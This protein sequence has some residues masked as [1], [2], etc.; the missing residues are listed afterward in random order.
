MAGDLNMVAAGRSM[1]LGEQLARSARKYPHKT[2]L[3]A[4]GASID[5]ATLNKNATCFA[6]AL[7]RR[8]IRQGDRIVVLMHNRIETIEAF[9]GLNRLGAIVVPVNYRLTDDEVEYIANDCGASGIVFEESLLPA[10]SKWL[11]SGTR[12][13]VCIELGDGVI[14]GAEAWN[15]AMVDSEITTEFEQ[16]LDHA[17]AFILYTSGT[18]GRPKGALLTHI[19]LLMNSLTMIRETEMAGDDDVWLCGNPLFHVAGVNWLHIHILVGGTL[20]LMPFGSFDPTEVVK[21]LESELITGCYFVPSQWQQICE[22]PGIKDR[23]FRLRRI[24]WGASIAPLKLLEA[25]AGLFSSVPI[26]NCFGQTEMSGLT[27]ILKGKDAIR[28]MGSVG[29]PVL[30]IDVRI[31]SES[32]QDVAVGQVGEIVYRGPTTLL[33]Y[34]HNPEA[35]A[36]A[37]RGGWFH[38]GDLCRI[39]EEGYIWVVD[40]VKDMIVSGG[41]NIYPAEVENAIS[42][43]PG[44]RLVAVVAGPHERWIE[45]PVAFVVPR[46][47]DRAP[48]QQ[49]IVEWCSAF[50]ASY[51]KPT[52]V[53]IVESLPVNASG[54]VLKRVL[55]DQLWG[56]LRTTNFA[57]NDVGHG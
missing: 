39:D 4:A 10:A 22:V 50:I 34:W 8:G 2:A 19:N 35:T 30:N 55:R 46:E 7:W 11:R 13:Q 3:R 14:D 5:Y 15:A 56:D 26:Y 28:K 43:H 20:V 21:L 25:I 37:F 31:V 16:I 23:H 40:R 44:V 18:T 33:E 45:T 29:Q 49:E 36:E 47:V 51:K 9:Y 38:S 32:M 24:T 52:L 48:T 12:P 57:S 1:S 42:R 41:E 54:K 53:V 17:P 6:Q 27:C